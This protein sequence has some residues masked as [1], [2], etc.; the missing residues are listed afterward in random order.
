MSGCHYPSW[1][2]KGKKFPQKKFDKI[3]THEGKYKGNNEGKITANAEASKVES[4]EA[5]LT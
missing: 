3:Q 5:S 1:H 2:P 4:R